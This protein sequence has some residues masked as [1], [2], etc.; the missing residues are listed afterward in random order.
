MTARKL[1]SF[2]KYLVH[3]GVSVSARSLSSFL[4]R[5]SRA[6]LCSVA[7]SMSPSRRD[8]VTCCHSL[9]QNKLVTWLLQR[10]PSQPPQT[11]GSLCNRS[12]LSTYTWQTSPGQSTAVLVRAHGQ[13]LDLHQQ[14][15]T[16]RKSSEV[17]AVAIKCLFVNLLKLLLEVL[18][19]NQLLVRM[20]GAAL[21]CSW[22][23]K[24]KLIWRFYSLVSTLWT[25]KKTPSIHK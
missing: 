19:N 21:L 15:G 12:T 16:G 22:W 13:V 17:L 24:K 9:L 23:V 3:Q 20:S 6:R 10:L 1:T 18:F 8:S 4:C 14:L 25:Q 5:S 2:R 7:L 11:A